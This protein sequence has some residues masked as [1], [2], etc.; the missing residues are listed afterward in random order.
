MSPATPPSRTPGPRGRRP[1][2]QAV[3]AHAGVSR[4]TVS[5]VVNGVGSV[6]PSL[7][8]RVAQ[9]VRD[10]HYVPNPAARSLMTQ[11]TDTVALIAAES[12]T[13]LFGDPFF[14][15]VVR[16]VG[17]E[18]ARA[19]V[20]LL[21][22]LVSSEEELARAESFL[23]GGHVDGALVISEHDSV[24]VVGHAAAAGL[25]V[26]VGGRPLTP[27]PGLLFVDHDN[28][29]GAAL[30]TR[31]LVQAGRRRIGTV[32]GP[33]DMS[34]GVD[35]LT[36]FREA[37]GSRYDPEL[38]EP[39]DFTREGGR[40]A[41]SRLVARRPDLDA[42]F[43]AS[44]LMAAGGLEALGAAGRRVPEDVSVVGF[45]DAEIGATT[46]PALTTIRQRSTDQGRLMAQLLL[47]EL[48]RPV[49]DPLSDLT[50]PGDDGGL[51]LG[52]ELVVRS[53]G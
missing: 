25:P 1:T 41:M 14:A 12:P 24:D 8:E 46:S 16:A 30:A 31:H 22:S 7:A 15:A 44:D 37:L 19:E 35:R 11:R 40:A 17:Q 38:V 3:A 29:G 2:L 51:V 39:G 23:R 53:S 6:D 34:A 26:V 42:V 13:R 21:L 50:H 10:L 32:T 20:H 43:V 4:A 47:Q 36:G 52:V 33:A 48:G 27:Y 28:V 9:A 5:R 18:L 49:V 45:D